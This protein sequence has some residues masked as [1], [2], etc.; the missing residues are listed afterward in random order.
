ML[1]SGIKRGNWPRDEDVRYLSRGMQQKVA[2]ATE[3][4]FYAARE[5][6]RNAAKHAHPID[7]EDSLRLIITAGWKN[8]L[9][10]IIEDNGVGPIVP[11][12]GS[13]GQG[14]IL[15]STMMAVVGGSL[16][17]ESAP[18]LPTRVILRLP[19]EIAV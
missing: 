2:L 16:A 13:S 18:G 14:L 1:C 11:T 8:G 10:I 7:P 6:L 4:A 3:V 15:H 12:A 5:A 9:E 17:L 19:E